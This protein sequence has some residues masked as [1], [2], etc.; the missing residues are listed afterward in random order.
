M[1]VALP[2][3]RLTKFLEFFD[4][5]EDEVEEDFLPIM[6]YFGETYVIGRPARGRRRAV[7]P[8]YAPAV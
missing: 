8:R 3:Y 2:L 4:L 7:V 5:L 6:Q 1:I